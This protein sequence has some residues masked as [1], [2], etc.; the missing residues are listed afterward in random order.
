[1]TIVPFDVM[2]LKEQRTECWTQ[3]E[4]DETGND[5]RG[6]D[7]HRELLEEQARNTR[8]ECHRYEDGAE[9]YGNCEQ[10]RTH[11]VHRLVRRPAGLHARAYVA[12]YIFHDNDGVVDHDTY[13][14]YQAKKRQIVN[15]DS[16]RHEYRKGA[17]Q[18]D[19]NGDDGNDGRPPGLQ[20]DED[21]DDHQ[22]NCDEDR[23]YNLLHRLSDKVRGVID[24]LIA[25]AGWEIR[26]KSF[27]SRKDILFDSQSIGAG[28]ADSC[29]VT[30]IVGLND[31]VSK[32]VRSREASKCFD[33]DLVGSVSRLRRS[34]QDAGGDLNILCAQRG[35]NVVGTEV[36]GSCLVRIEPHAHSVLA[37]ALKIG[38]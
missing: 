37:F 23:P 1:M 16:E 21:Y 18:R 4:R 3:S 38:F 32:L 5:R 36:I 30:L 14:K 20:E 9:C 29:N 22:S 27:Y 28:I 12:L 10:R 26:R 7:G 19:R 31:D 33:A 34:I 8:N 2:A 17:N 11:F 25:D 24:D 13:G 15:R 6:R 35:E